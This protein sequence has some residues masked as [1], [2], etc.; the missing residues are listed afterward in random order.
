MLETPQMSDVL[1]LPTH[2]QFVAALAKHVSRTASWVE[3]PMETMCAKREIVNSGCLSLDSIIELF[4]AAYG[5]TGLKDAM[6]TPEELG[7]EVEGNWESVL[8]ECR[9]FGSYALHV[10]MS[11]ENLRSLTMALQLYN[12]FLIYCFTGDMDG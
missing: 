1:D 4:H 12:A 3:S 8:R 7:L 6:V 11:G 10:A 5:G 9:R 2:D